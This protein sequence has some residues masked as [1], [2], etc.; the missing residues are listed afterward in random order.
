MKVGDRVIRYPTTI[1]AYDN[2]CR[3]SRTPMSGKVVYVHP[4]GRFH[5]V[6]FETCGGTIRESFPGVS[7]VIELEEEHY[8]GSGRLK[9]AK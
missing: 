5:T 2:Q 4:L 6:A 9:H 8:K 3:A 7:E 1:L